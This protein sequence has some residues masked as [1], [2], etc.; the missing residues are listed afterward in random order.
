MSWTPEDLDVINAE[1][2]GRLGNLF[3]VKEYCYPKQYNFLADQS[4]YADAVTTRR[5]GKTTGVAANHIDT[6]LRYPGDDSL[7]I[8][9]TRLNAKKLMWP[10]ALEILEKYKIRVTPNISELTL[11]FPNKSMIYLAGVNDSRAIENFRGMKL[12]LVSIDEPQSMRAYIEQL[13]DDVLAPALMDLNGKMRMT[14]T[15]G[16]VPAG[17]FYK[18][19]QNAAWSHHNFSLFDNPHIKDPWT[20]INLELARRGVDINHPSIQREYFG[21]WVSDPDALVIKYDEALNDYDGLPMLEHRLGKWEYVVGVDLGYHDSDAIGVLAFHPRV[22]EVY[23]VEEII[24]PKQGITPLI[25]QLQEVYV[26]Y[27]PHKVVMDTG[28]LGKKIA[29]EITQRFGIPVAAAEKTRKLEYYELLNDALRTRRFKA[30]KN[31]R[32]AQDSKLLEWDKDSRDKDGKFV[33]SENFHSDIIDT[34]LYGYRESLHWLHEPEI[35]LPKPGTQA[36][37]DREEQKIKEKLEAELENQHM[38]ENF[39]RILPDS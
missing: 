23:L 2:S 20:R 26:K 8:T 7:Y 36:F 33:V 22:P 37:F 18:I 27:R 5:S 30:K 6:A 16:A 1:L 14:G 11:T 21:R 4:L 34:V 10:I 29:E 32:F 9:L 15:P 19:T 31:S 17:Y 28:G 39:Y 38:N 12:R 24:T 13:I 35:I 3:N 25:S